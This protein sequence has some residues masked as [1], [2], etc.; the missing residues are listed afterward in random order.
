MTTRIVNAQ[1]CDYKLRG[2]TTIA[3]WW[4]KAPYMMK[5]QGFAYTKN[6]AISS[7]RL[8]NAEPGAPDTY[9]TSEAIP[10]DI[11]KACMVVLT[12]LNSRT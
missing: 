3:F 10:A 5:C 6:G 9:L 1:L 11:F 12:C 2:Q 8:C 7:A 4:G